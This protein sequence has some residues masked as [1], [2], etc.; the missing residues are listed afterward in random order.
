MDEV[1][2]FTG[3]RVEAGVKVAVACTNFM[4]CYELRQDGIQF[5]AKL[6]RFDP[7]FVRNLDV[8]DIVHGIH[9]G[10]C[11]ACS[12]DRDMLSEE[13]LKSFFEF[14]LHGTGIVLDLPAAECAAVV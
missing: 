9:S 3:L 8:G 12:C 14:T 7:D 4:N 2:I 5:V 10:V 6:R 11:P 13:L 1:V